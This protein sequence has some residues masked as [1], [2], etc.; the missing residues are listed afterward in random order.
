[1][2]TRP[3]DA[4]FR[5]AFEHPEAA[6]AELRHV[7]P[8]ELVEAI[9]FTTLRLEPGSFVD[10]HLADRHT[11]LLFSTSIAGRPAHVYLL[12]EHQ[13]TPDPRMPLRLLVYMVRIWERWTDTNP[14][15]PLPP[16]IPVVVMHPTHG[17]PMPTRLHDLVAPPPASIP[18]LA[19]SVPDFR[20]TID[21]ISFATDGEL[22]SRSLAAFPMLALSLLR[23]GRDEASLFANLET[24]AAAYAAVAAAPSGIHAFERLM[25]YVELR[26]SDEQLATFHARLIE[27]APT[28][29]SMVM[30]YSERLIAEGEAKGEAKGEARGLLQGRLETQRDILRRLL[31]RRFGTLDLSTLARVDTA[32]S[33]ELEVW[34]DRIVL[35]ADLDA[36]F[37][38]DRH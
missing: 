5:S 2:T 30:R 4:L 19:H 8:R 37:R 17:P 7:L 26:L 29:E 25:R 35:A 27:L 12:L 24:W 21:D 11:D 34:L 32:E 13:S 3:H 6:A 28:T 20:I 14:E 16:I 22:R 10:P 33:A 36:V 15:D 38:D 23:D 18:G 1:M 31:A 9:D